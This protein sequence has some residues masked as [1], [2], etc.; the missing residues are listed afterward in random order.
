MRNNVNEP[1]MV[2]VVDRVFDRLTDALP[3]YV[4]TTPSKQYATA[5]SLS[6]F[7]IFIIVIYSIDYINLIHKIILNML[8]GIACFYL[9]G[10]LQ[11]KLFNRQMLSQ[12]KQ[13]FANISWLRRYLNY[14]SIP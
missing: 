5:V 10:V 3:K 6:L 14:E 12:N 13:H 2:Q 11:E 4:S 7:F 1:D 9:F 8:S